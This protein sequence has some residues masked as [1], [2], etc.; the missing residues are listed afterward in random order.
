MRWPAI[1]SS[2]SSQHC[3]LPAATARRPGLWRAGSNRLADAQSSLGVAKTGHRYLAE[4]LSTCGLDHFF[5]VPLVLPEAI[6]EMQRLGVRPIV[7]HTEK[8][9]AYMADGYARASG[10]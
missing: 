6:K 3:Q 10:R 4:A 1:A 2:S 8:A 7:A 9:A 5:H